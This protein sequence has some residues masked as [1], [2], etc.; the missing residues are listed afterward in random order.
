MTFV[1]GRRVLVDYD[2]RSEEYS[3]YNK[4]RWKH[5]RQF[6]SFYNSKQWRNT[7]KRILLQ[8]D[9]VCA[10]CGGEAVLVDHIIPIRIDWNKRFDED[11]CQPLCKECHN[12]KTILENKVYNN[13][14]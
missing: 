1:G 13:E 6:V 14:S 3:D 12:K 8:Y 10:E 9:Y 11:N 2:S 5:D 4:M 7:S